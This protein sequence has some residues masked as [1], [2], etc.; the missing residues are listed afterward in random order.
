MLQ[1][2][3]LM[4]TSILEPFVVR[5]AV[6]LP[7]ASDRAIVARAARSDAYRIY[8]TRTVPETLARLVELLEG[9]KVAMI[10]DETP[11]ALHGGP[12]LDGLRDAGLDVQVSAVPTGEASKSLEQAVRLWNWLAR[13]S[14]ARRDVILTFG[15][16][17]VNDTGGWVASAYMRGIPYVN[18]PTTL[19]A[20]VDAAL[21]GKV[22]V[23]HAVAKNLLGA[24]YQPVGVV[25]NVE[26]LQTVDDRH[27][28]A[29]L[30]EAIKKA[31]IASPAYWDFI[32]GNLDAIL[33]RDLG[34]LERLVRCASAIKTAL[35]ER[36]PYEEDLRRP[37]NFGHTIA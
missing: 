29:G 10:T 3:Q 17:V 28:R 30:A 37:L 4:P 12:L 33:A 8:V 31:I 6:P 34:A 26:Y 36:D 1:E 25:S 23:N 24:F 19:L 2:A 20:Q 15:G 21:G 16:G 11:M 27:L 13:S 22:A 32:E 14:L 5:Y 9:A 7:A 18:V 35:I